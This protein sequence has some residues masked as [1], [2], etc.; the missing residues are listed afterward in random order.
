METR[1]IEVRRILN[2]VVGDRVPYHSGKGK[3]WDLPRNDFVAAVVRGVPVIVVGDPDASGLIKAIRGTSPFDGS[4][5]ERMPENGPYVPEADIVFIEGWIRDG[6][7]DVDSRAR[8]PRITE[9]TTE[10][11]TAASDLAGTEC[12]KRSL[13]AA[14]TLEFATVPPY[15]T[16]MWSLKNPNST[17]AYTLYDVAVEEM[18]HMG[19]ACNMLAGL[20]ESP[21][22]ATAEYVPSYPGPLPGEVNP[23][24]LITL[25][26]L[27]PEQVKVFM[28]IEYPEGGP[29]TVRAGRDFD[30]IGAFYASLL[31][32]FE[33]INP[34][35]DTTNQ[36]GEGRLKKLATLADVRWAIDLIRRQGE[37]SK[38]DQSPEDPDGGLAHFYQ[39][40]EIY[41]GARYVKDPMTD[42]WGHTGPPVVLPEVWPMADVPK[43]GYQRA[44]IPD[45]AVWA[46]IEAFDR[47]FTT[48]LHQLERAWRDP[49]ASLDDAIDS[50]RALSPIAL[51]IVNKARPDGYGNYGP[52]FRML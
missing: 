9:L 47:T 29:I 6:C 30:T 5:F 14:I 41:V 44:D 2:A 50:M 35:L 42:V 18:N 34:P 25:R 31:E 32:A 28:D 19:L 36:R 33:R 8:S 23:Q 43:G 17:V 7:P 3:F 51:E 39:F 24:L 20:G 16:A 12:L 49:T 22:L 21:A 1:L 10:L 52:C 48:M 26:R 27:T 38:Q 37:G 40:R 11:G 45:A 46:S 4:R 13:R 15:L